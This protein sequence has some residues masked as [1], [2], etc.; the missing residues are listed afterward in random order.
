MK[1]TPR[2]KLKTSKLQYHLNVK[3]FAKST[4]EISA[5]SG[6]GE[7]VAGWLAATEITLKRF[8]TK[9]KI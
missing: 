2:G 7:M 1:K 8:C 5:T 3:R 9:K 6:L 4:T